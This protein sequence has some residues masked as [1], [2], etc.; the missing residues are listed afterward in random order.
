MSGIAIIPVRDFATTKLRLKSSLDEKKRA[1]LTAA[2]LKNVLHAVQESELERVVV[3]AANKE[4]AQKDL[5]GFSKLTVIEESRHNG[6]VNQAM[7]DGIGAL[8]KS[9]EG[10]TLLFMPSDL[11][12]LNSDA[13][14]KVMRLMKEYDLLIIGSNKKDGTNLLGMNRPDLIP[15]HYD[16]DSFTKHLIEAESRNLNYV[17]LDWQEFSFDVDDKD[18]LE[19][20]MRLKQVGSFEDLI[21]KLKR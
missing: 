4:K 14:N 2:L 5:T 18:D 13:L 6:G 17:M 7:R 11:P 10:H 9:A 8:G 20:L 16:D 3:V 15:M 1:T 21:S 19:K 12:L